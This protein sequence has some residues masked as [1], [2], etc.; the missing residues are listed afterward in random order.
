MT[1]ETRPFK[2]KAKII[3]L[4]LSIGKKKKQKPPDEGKW[5]AAS[6]MDVQNEMPEVPSFRNPK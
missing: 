1:P 5:S 3:S 2:V 6:E 4:S